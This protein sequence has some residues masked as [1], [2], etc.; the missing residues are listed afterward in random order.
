MT[1]LPVVNAW[2][3]SCVRPLKTDWDWPVLLTS[4]VTGTGVLLT[5]SRPSFRDDVPVFHVPVEENALNKVPSPMLQP[6]SCPLSSASEF[7]I[8]RF[9]KGSSLLISITR[10]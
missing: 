3:W 2:A 1:A 8:R 5:P 6:A 9:E 7:V 4:V 10:K